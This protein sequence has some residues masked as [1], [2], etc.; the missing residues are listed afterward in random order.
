MAIDF[1]AVKAPARK[2]GTPRAKAAAPVVETRSLREVREE[3]LL[4]IGQLAQAGCVSMGQLADAGAVG[5]FFPPIAHEIAVLAET[6]T[7][8]ANMADVLLKVGPYAGL[9]T[10]M[11]PLVF[12]VAVN[13]GM[14]NNGMGLQNFNV[15]PKETLEAQ[16]RAELTRQMLE[17]Q[18]LHA[19]AL[20]EAAK[21]EEELRGLLE[22]QAG[23]TK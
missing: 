10:A 23:K 14:F 21:A 15:V 18:Q 19:E 4:G 8:A 17:M 2:T 22:A 3:G 9:V 6:N 13:H 11:L 12:Q 20:R 7:Y 1:S 16:M 5:R